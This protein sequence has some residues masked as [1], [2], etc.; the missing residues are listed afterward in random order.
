M[1]SPWAAVLFAW[2]IGWVIAAC[3]F[4]RDFKDAGTSFGSDM[5]TCASK[6]RYLF[7]RIMMSLP[8]YAAV[9]HFIVLGVAWR[10]PFMRFDPA[11]ALCVFDAATVFNP[12]YAG[13]CCV[14]TAAS[15][16]VMLAM[17]RVERVTDVNRTGTATVV[18]GAL[19]PWC[20]ALLLALQ[21]NGCSR[22]G[23]L[24]LPGSARPGFLLVGEVC[25]AV[26]VAAT[27]LVV[28]G[29]TTPKPAKT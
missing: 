22:L 20:V 19:T 9:W 18:L 25:V 8:L 6:R 16:I 13:A 26:G 2:F 17:S 10:L 15:C 5:V 21:L 1:Q 12:A 14:A 28:Y 11:S 29:R 4:A 27:L 7:A 24:R 3:K 23:A